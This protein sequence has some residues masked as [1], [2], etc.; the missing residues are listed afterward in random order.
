MINDSSK[1]SAKN[2]FSE[3][4]LWHKFSKI[5]NDMHFLCVFLK[6]RAFSFDGNFVFCGENI[7]LY[8]GFIMV[9]SLILDFLKIRITL[10]RMTD[11]LQQVKKMRKTNFFE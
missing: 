3:F 11:N 2:Y 1:I 9:Q 7:A 8:F 6:F 5:N 4:L 10:L